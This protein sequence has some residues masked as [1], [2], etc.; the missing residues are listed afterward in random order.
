M[1]R[2]V[3]LLFK[4]FAL[5]KTDHS[6]ETDLHW[7]KSL[8]NLSSEVKRNYLMA[9]EDAFLAPLYFVLYGFPTLQDVPGVG[10]NNTEQ[11]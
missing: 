5:F 3:G 11:H 10:L 2:E 7:H 1:C 4:R 8:A 9:V 6:S